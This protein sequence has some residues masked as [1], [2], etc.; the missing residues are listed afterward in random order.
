MLYLVNS[1]LEL[2]VML[3]IEYLKKKLPMKKLRKEYKQYIE[4]MNT[5]RQQMSGSVENDDIAGCVQCEKNEIE[6]VL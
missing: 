3:D 2:L 5:V 6:N 1:Q 4:I